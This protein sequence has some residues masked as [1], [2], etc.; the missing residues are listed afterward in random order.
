MVAKKIL[1]PLIQRIDARD[2]Q[3][4]FLGLFLGLGVSIRDWTLCWDAIA[5][6]IAVCLVV[7]LL[8]V[9]A[10]SRSK[11]IEPVLNRGSWPMALT[12]LRSALITSL[13]LCL[14]LRANSI[15]TISIASALAISSKFLVRWRGKHVFN[16][17]NFSII[18][19]LLFTSDAWISPGQWGTDAWL[20]LAFAGAGGLVLRRVGRWD[21]SAAFLGTYALLVSLRNLWLG[22]EWD[23]IVHHLSSGSLLLFALFMLTDPRTIPNARAGRLVWAAAIALAS[24]ILSYGF[25][26]Q[27]APFWAL[28]AFAPLTPLFD[29]HWPAP[30]FTWSEPSP[31]TAG[32]SL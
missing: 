9:Y 15:L 7:Q 28:F 11:A 12:S 32:L 4:G 6:A 1:M 3:I 8:W 19:A 30:R 24:F 5:V 25:Y 31:A 10:R 2:Y 20:V 29:K 17:A 16:P 26:V 27:A 18:A 21:T 14:L 13:S 23:A 22:W